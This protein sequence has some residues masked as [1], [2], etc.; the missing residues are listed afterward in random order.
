MTIRTTPLSRALGAE[1]AGVDLARPLDDATFDAVHAAWMDHL[2]IVL[3]EQE[4]SDTQLEQFSAEQINIVTAG[5]FE[6]QQ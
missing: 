1:V 6:S 5:T 2:V 3:R 4:L